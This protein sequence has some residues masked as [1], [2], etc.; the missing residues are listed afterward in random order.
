MILFYALWLSD[1]AKGERKWVFQKSRYYIFKALKLSIN[2][3]RKGEK[4]MNERQNKTCM[5]SLDFRIVI[6]KK[7][8]IVEAKFSKFILM[9]PKTQVKNQR[10]VQSRIKIKVKIQE[11]TQLR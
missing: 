10:V 7:G 5:Y 1:V 2:S 9:M 8:E 11:N 6:I 4:D 3:K